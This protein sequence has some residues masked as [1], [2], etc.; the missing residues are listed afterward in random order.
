MADV[1]LPYHRKYRPKSLNGYVG[2]TKIKKGV[3]SALS[4][5]Q[6]PQVVLMTGH[7]GTGKTTMARLLAKEYLCENRDPHIGACGECHSCKLMEEYIE[8][9]DTGMLM[10]VREI[11]VTDSSGKQDITELLE[12]ASVPSFD[13]SWKIFIL[14]ECHMMTNAAQNRLLKNL[15]E[16]AEKVLM[17]LCTTDPQKLLETIIS[18]CQY[19]FKV[20][21]PTRD[22]LCQLLARVLTKE[23][24]KY[25]DKAL[26]LICVK[27]DFVPR[28]T[29]I[30]L[31]QVVREAK[32]VTYEKTVEVLDLVSDRLYF[33]FYNLLLKENV[34][35]YEYIA[36]LGK[37][38]AST[39]LKQFVES[40]IPFTVR[41][42]YIAN[43][44]EVEALDTSEIALYKKLFKRLQPGDV[45]YLLNLL[46]DMKQSL[47][48]ETKLMLLGYVGILNR[49]QKEVKEEAKL[50]DL[51]P[52]THGSASVEKEEST[53]NFL[54]S[55]TMSK[56]EEEEFIEKHSK[57][58]SPTDIANIFGGT[59]VKGDLP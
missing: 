8:T 39:D 57:T 46:L 24:V 14:D 9:G 31:E 1:Y 4:G 48:V 49:G 7:A 53:K 59:I 47:D 55:I 21:K 38:K 56:E 58:L 5:E 10:N 13:G 25:D 22:E 40:L 2:N 37:L 50:N 30:A 35:I 43:G 29:L 19:V 51:V 34:N 15:E 3:L 18:R 45:A 36:F 52:V 23:G 32:E 12:D 28:K 44:V 27:G 33:D 20:Q 6:K 11:D 17:V 42:I 26:S 16:P 54:S 41:G